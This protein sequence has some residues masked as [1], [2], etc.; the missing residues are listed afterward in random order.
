[1][2]K[3]FV[4]EL[5]LWEDRDRRAQEFDPLA[6][7]AGRWR[8]KDFYPSRLRHIPGQ[9]ITPPLPP[10]K[11]YV[12]NSVP[13]FEYFITSQWCDPCADL[14]FS[15]ES[16]STHAVKFCDYLESRADTEEWLCPLEGKI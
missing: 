10:D 7:G 6:G 5:G 16:N 4:H 8:H 12:G 1:M 3:S 11:I 9:Q 2:C 14:S 13:G 15:T